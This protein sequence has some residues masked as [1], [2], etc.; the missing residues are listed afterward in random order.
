MKPLGQLAELERESSRSYPRIAEVS[1]LLDPAARGAV[2]QYLRNGTPVFDVME[3]TTHPSEPSRR[4]PGGSSLL[5]DGEW[6]WRVDLADYVEV[7]N[8]GLP[9]EFVSKANS[10]K[11]IP[12]VHVSKELVHEALV[13]FG[14][15]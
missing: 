8:L 7:F 13:A 11:P 2:V 1:G 3:A 12:A 14:W 10:G 6:A 5:T 9:T 15:V 4:I